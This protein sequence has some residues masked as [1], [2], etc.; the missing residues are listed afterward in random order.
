MARILNCANCG[1]PFPI[2]ARYCA[3]C[4]S[5]ALAHD[6]TFVLIPARQH[7]PLGNV[8]V[9][10]REIPTV[11]QLALEWSSV[12]RK[13]QDMTWSG[14]EQVEDEEQEDED[15][16]TVQSTIKHNGSEPGPEPG[17]NWELVVIPA[18]KPGLAGKLRPLYPY[19]VLSS[20][21]GFWLVTGL[22]TV[23][24]VGGFFGIALTF[25]DST[26]QAT[27]TA[28]TLSASPTTV[29]L[30]KTINLSGVFPT[31]NGL[32]TLSRDNNI[33]LI[34]TYN[35]NS[36]ITDAHGHL[37]TTVVVEPDWGAGPHTLYGLDVKTKQKAEINITAEGQTVPNGPPHL[38][39]SQTAL[40]LG[41]QDTT[42]NSST[43]IALS[44]MGSGQLDWQASSTQP[45]LQLTPQSGTI[46]GGESTWVTVVG[47][48][49]NLKPGDYNAAIVFTSI[50]DPA[51]TLN[52]KMSVTA[53]QPGHQAVMQVSTSTLT[54][55]GIKN[56]ADPASKNLSVENTGYQTLTW[57]ATV[58]TSNG[59]N[60]LS[61]SQYSGTVAAGGKQTLS[62]HTSMAGLNPGTYQGT[63]LLSNTGKQPIQGNP[64]GIFVTLTVQPACAL[65]FLPDSL[66]FSVIQGQGNPGADTLTVGSSTSCNSSQFWTAST[67]TTTGGNWLSISQTTGTAPD[68]I[69]VSVNASGLAAGT[70]TGAMS[71]RNITGVQQNVYVTLNVNLPACAIAASTM[72]VSFQGTAGQTT[73][74]SQT[75]TLSDAGNCQNTLNW[76]GTATV[77]TP[78]GGTWLSS[79]ASGTLNPASTAAVE[80][81][82]GFNGLGAGTYTGTVTLTA[83]DR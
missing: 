44:N 18:P 70:Y 12:E 51:I 16:A 59:T 46:A 14:L 45:W 65:A 4:G 10:E 20:Q 52:V 74:Q 24:L 22:L 8:S 17:S 71:F 56:G 1:E 7:T 30:G 23:L 39:L 38:S 3:G 42:I 72:F 21:L 25:A 67:S 41:T 63:I 62:V 31:S 78:T 57:G 37:H 83:V 81:M 82:A 68:N 5:P 26:N 49:A 61:I 47:G 36:V 33:K 58:T 32:V 15:E 11:D 80:L 76:T 73:A 69:Q 77:N 35:T 28:P 48:R 75:V 53:I 9:A 40:D 50:N 13:R 60:W 79:T 43:E 55:T 19:R 34:D 27:P 29:A 6:E 66:S 64:Q 54:F 2:N